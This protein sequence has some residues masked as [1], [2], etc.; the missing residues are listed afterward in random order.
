MSFNPKVPYNNLPSLPPPQAIETPAVLRAVI[1]AARALAE[2][3]AATSLLPNPD[4][5]THTVALL[6][7]GA[8][9][10]IE[11]IVTTHDELFR[12]LGE[13][14]GEVNIATKE[15]LRYRDA[16]WQG[17]AELRQG[18]PLCTNL[19]IQLMQTLKDTRA[20]LR[21][22]PGTTLTNQN[23]KEVVYT[24]PVG[25]AVLRDK[26]GNLD[27]FI[28]AQHLELDP[29]IKMAI[30]HYQFEAIHPFH[31]GNGR[32]GRILCILQ[33]MEDG[34]LSEPVL[35]LSR[36]IIQ[37]KSDYYRLL[38]AVTSDGAWEPWLLFMLEGV[39][40]TAKWTLAKI[41][42][43]QALMEK[44]EAQMRLH[45][46]KQARVRELAELLVERPYCKTALIE[47]K[48]LALRQTASSYLSILAEKGLLDTVKIG[49]ENVYIN[50]ALLAVLRGD[51]AGTG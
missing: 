14:E 6:E 48:G 51:G 30:V 49:R 13:T 7:A 42:A 27:Q 2:L 34:L 1:R 29:L 47:Q 31:D 23:T 5:L 37:R 36:H 19:Y 18:R 39:E 35:Y 33:L 22:V 17:V 4:I 3:K 43:V 25:E 28:H 20:G 8:S 44:M 46:P 40:V 9:S 10:E 12:A 24:P 11:N 50:S 41:Q 15:V 26:L 45:L 38:R 32:T 21:Q 16:L